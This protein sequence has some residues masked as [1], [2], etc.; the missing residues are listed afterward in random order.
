MAEPPEDAELW[1]WRGREEA[2]EDAQRLRHGMPPICCYRCHQ[3]RSMERRLTVCP[4]CERRHCADCSRPCPWRAAARRLGGETGSY[5][6]EAEEEEEEEEDGDTRRC[7]SGHWC[8]TCRPGRWQCCDTCAEPLFCRFHLLDTARCPACTQQQRREQVVAEQAERCNLCCAA[9]PAGEVVRCVQAAAG[10][11]M[12]ACQGCAASVWSRDNVGD[13]YCRLCAAALGICDAYQEAREAVEAV[14]VATAYE[15]S[16]RERVLEAA[17]LRHEE[18]QRGC[19]FCP[20]AQA[21]QLACDGCGQRVC[22]QHCH[23][24]RERTYAQDTAWC[25]DCWRD[26]DSFALPAPAAAAPAPPPRRRR[27]KRRHSGADQ[28]V[29]APPEGGE[30]APD[31]DVPPPPAAKRRRRRRQRQ[32]AAPP[33]PAE[34]A[35][36]YAL[37]PTSPR[38]L[39]AA[40]CSRS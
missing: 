32:E 16:M 21:T 35:S 25:P 13:S 36:I 30:T 12:H 18:Q 31:P 17:R 22:D 26:D 9:C 23:R 20:N 40:Q 19:P 1:L 7:T 11:E 4:G 33:P 10:C 28:Q 24:V 5:A 6:E 34:D 14:E 8:D 39:S 37:Q 3:L 27:R 29:S 15:Q 38:G 2:I